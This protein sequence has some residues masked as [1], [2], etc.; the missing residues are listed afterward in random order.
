MSDNDDEQ[1]HHSRPPTPPPPSPPPLSDQE[2][3]AK[4]REIKDKLHVLE[5]KI[6]TDE[7]VPDLSPNQTVVFLRCCGQIVHRK[8][9]IEWQFQHEP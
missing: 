2:I 7:I 9:L 6:C 5:C 3:I 8:C 1:Q 4:L